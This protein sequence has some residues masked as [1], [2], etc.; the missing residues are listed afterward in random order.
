MGSILKDKVALVTGASRGIGEAIARRL[1]SEGATVII[2]AR[3][4]AGKGSH[5]GGSVGVGD[6][7]VALAGSLNE[8]ADRIRADGGRAIAIQC[9]VGDPA[10]RGALYDRA[11][12]ATG[13]VDIL[14]NNAAT[15]VYGRAWNAISDEKRDQ[16]WEVNFHAPYD[17]MCRFVP[18]MVSRGRGWVINISSKTAELPELPFGPFE[19]HSGVMLYGAA[20]AALNRLGVGVAAELEGTGVAV[21]TFAPFSVVWTPGA[22]QTGVDAY[23]DQPGWVEEPVEGMAETALA[24]AS[25]DPDTVSGLCVYSTPYL[26]EIGREIMTLDGREPLRG[27]K[28]SVA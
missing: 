5:H 28:P 20:K 14:V 18:Q 16:V 3:T 13:R 2:T 12:S 21:N 6:H 4:V 19:R 26:K 10:A 11:M 17:L 23:R 22:A 15:A 8:V 27:W 9:D 24:F 1:A 25:C 7:V